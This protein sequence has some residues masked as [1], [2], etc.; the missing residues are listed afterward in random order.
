M[1]GA[2]ALRVRPAVRLSTNRRS[3][4]YVWICRHIKFRRI[5][6]SSGGGDDGEIIAFFQHGRRRRHLNIKID[7]WRQ[8]AHARAR[9]RDSISPCCARGKQQ[10]PSEVARSNCRELRPRHSGSPDRPTAS[11]AVNGNLTK[12]RSA[13]AFLDDVAFLISRLSTPAERPAQWQDERALS[14]SLS[15]ILAQPLL[16]HPSPVPF[17]Q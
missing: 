6:C 9:P 16:T 14:L 5:C 10:F 8:A 4:I 13:A 1:G 15:P 17:P 11:F 7:E 3:K 2:A 12:E